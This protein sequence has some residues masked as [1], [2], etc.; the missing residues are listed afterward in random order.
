MATAIVSTAERPE[1]MN[2]NIYKCSVDLDTGYLVDLPREYIISLLYV[3]FSNF[4][5]VLAP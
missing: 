5:A 1:K 4:L 2:V 3:R